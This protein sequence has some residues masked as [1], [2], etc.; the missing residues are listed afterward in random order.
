VVPIDNGRSNGNILLTDFHFQDNKKERQQ[1]NK[2][3]H[4]VLITAAIDLPVQGQGDFSS[5]AAAGYRL[6]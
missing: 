4:P 2:P 5:Y 3:G 6:V 1:K